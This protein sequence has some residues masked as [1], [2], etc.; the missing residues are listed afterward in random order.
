MKNSIV[1][2]LLMYKNFDKIN[3]TSVPADYVTGINSAVVIPAFNPIPHLVEFVQGLIGRGIPRVI[4]VNDGSDASSDYIFSRLKHIK[5]CTVLS[6]DVNRGKGRALKTAFSYF[7][8][9]YSG[10]D[11]VVTADADGQHGI[12]D[13][14]NICKLISRKCNSLILGVRNF[15]DYNVPK[16]S[17]VGNTITSRI[18]QFLY[19]SYINDTQTGLRG[20]PKGELDWMIELKGERFDYEMN[21]LIEAVQRGVALSMVPIKTLYFNDNSGSNYNTVVDSFRISLCFAT[22]LMQYTGPSIITG[23]L[24]IFIFI[25]LNN[26]FLDFLAVHMRFFVS[27]VAARTLTSLCNFAINKGLAFWSTGKIVRPT[28]RFY[29]FWFVL[30]MVSFG[31]VY[32]ISCFWRINVAI[33]KLLVDIV[34]SFI[35]HYIHNC[36]FPKNVDKIGFD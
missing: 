29:I 30:M 17:Y 10:L 9:N 32:C 25:L 13:I 31:L 1:T 7:I 14:C 12:D 20:I 23:I 21:M 35:I 6:H 24:D 22:N 28:S 5:Q 11:G 26:Y 33:I 2:V 16:R 3:N 34:L 19:G 8:N 27:A 36:V 15:K 18:F 4:V